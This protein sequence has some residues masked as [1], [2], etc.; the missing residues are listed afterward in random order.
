MMKI[1]SVSPFFAKPHVGS[2][3]SSCPPKRLSCI[4]KHWSEMSGWEKI[5]AGP[6]LCIVNADEYDKRFGKYLEYFILYDNEEEYF[7][8]KGFAISSGRLLELDRQELHHKNQS[9][10]QHYEDNVV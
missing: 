9:V 4:D 10:C 7:E 6:F 8:V 5:E 3:I 1:I 2:R